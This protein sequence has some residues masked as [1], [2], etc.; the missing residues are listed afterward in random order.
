MKRSTILSSLAL[1]NSQLRLE[2]LL[3]TAL[4]IILKLTGADRAF[5]MLFDQDGKLD[6]TAAR[7]SKKQN[8][9]KADFR[10]SNTILQ[11]VLS[12]KK[13]LYLS[14]LDKSQDFESESVIALN[15]RSAICIPL[16][17][18][19]AKSSEGARLLGILY[20][21]SSSD[22][23]SLGE[24]QLRIIEALGSHLAISI[25]NARLFEELEEKNRQTKAQFSAILEE[26]SRISREIH[27]TLAQGLTGII[28]QLE[29]ARRMIAEPE[30]LLRHIARARESA[31]S[32]LAET[33]RSIWE[34][35]PAILEHSD[36]QEAL[37]RTAEQILAN[38]PTRV[39]F[40]VTGTVNLPAPIE[41]NLMRIAQEALWNIRKYAKAKVVKVELTLESSVVRLE[42]KDDGVGFDSAL[43]PRAGHFGL[44]GIRERI[45][46]LGGEFTICSRENQGTVLTIILP[47]PVASH[48]KA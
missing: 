19:Q 10:G 31:E 38:S 36:F 45:Q 24:R 9:R 6:I 34:L 11:K 13:S 4:D 28:L 22:T 2:R 5:L 12:D 48:E 20:V 7:N 16:W 21:D 39:E 30:A 44:T 27:D 41:D 46:K 35:R 47:L 8:L 3:P 33:K 37:S 18:P 29:A 14:N 17:R 32:T 25:E 1:L 42:M 43:L 26:R 15:L 40:Q 23:R